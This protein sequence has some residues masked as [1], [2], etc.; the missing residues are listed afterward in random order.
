MVPGLTGATGVSNVGNF[1]VGN[2]LSAY[3]MGSMGHQTLGKM[4]GLPQ[5]GASSFGAGAG[6][7]GGGMLSS[8]LLGAQLGTWAG[9]IGT[10]VGA[11]VGG[12]LGSFIPLGGDGNRHMRAQDVA[13]TYGETVDYGANYDDYENRHLATYTGPGGIDTGRNPYYGEAFGVL[14]KATNEAAASVWEQVDGLLLTFPEE[15]SAGIK[16][17][18]AALKFTFN[19][20]RSWVV[21]SDDFEDDMKAIL[22][23]FTTELYDGITP[24]IEKGFTDYAQNLVESGTQDGFFGRLSENNLLKT[25]LNNSKMF[26]EDFSK[27]EGVSFE[28]Y[29]AGVNEWLSTM[30]QVEQVFTNIDNT[31]EGILNPLSDFERGI[32]GIETQFDSL[33]SAL[34]QVG[35]STDEFTKMTEAQTRA[36]EN[37]T[38]RIADDIDLSLSDSINRM[39]LSE[40][41]YQSMKAADAL[42]ESLEKIAELGPEYAYLEEKARA[43]YDLQIAEQAQE[44][45][46]T[47]GDLTKSIGDGIT[48]FGLDEWDRQTNAAGQT[49]ADWQDQIASLVADEKLLPEMATAL[50]DKTQ[51]WLALTLDG[52]ESAKAATER[53]AALDYQ[54]FQYGIQNT[55]GNDL[56]IANMATKRGWDTSYGDI[57]DFDIERLYQEQVVPFIN[58]PFEDFKVSAEMMGMTWEELSSDTETLANIFNGLSTEASNVSDTFASLSESLRKQILDLQTSLANPADVMERRDISKGSISEYLGGNSVEEYLGSLGSPQEQASAISELQ[59]MYGTSLSVSQEAFQRPSMEYA[60]DYNETLTGL[61]SLLAFS[62]SMKTDYD[63][64]F[65]QTGYL[66]TIA[67]NT[68][69]LLAIP[70]YADGGYTPGGLVFTHPNELILNEDQQRSFTIPVST[71]NDSGNTV[72]ITINATGGNSEEVAEKIIKKVDSML[73]SMMV[74]GKNRVTI[75]NIAAGK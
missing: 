32:V 64:Q 9:P 36:I 21:A 34:Y 37:Y 16:E 65:E 30:S 74:R 49:L 20:D 63:L 40:S 4:V 70:Q 6:A 2:A 67:E 22:T 33:R 56:T 10:A 60:G 12:I 53:K 38:Q 47:I 28:N 3:G 11:A 69:S 17:D 55:T 29:I 59:G 26:N 15:I 24:V 31:V 58:M 62:D 14:E 13:L 18:L 57:G 66:K 46:R 23:N 44:T 50:L 25:S 43:V 39:T 45:A 42:S 48:S 27:A 61:D 51:E 5:G 68:A 19:E 7:V 41:D 72:Y 52:I 8:A 1:T 54:S 73:S 71:E 75:Q 35:A